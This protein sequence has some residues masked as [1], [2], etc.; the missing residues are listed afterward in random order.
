MKNACSRL[1]SRLEAV[2]AAE[3][4]F[5]EQMVSPHPNNDIQI[6]KKIL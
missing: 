1:S 3:G 2:I 5:F 6:V 4:Y